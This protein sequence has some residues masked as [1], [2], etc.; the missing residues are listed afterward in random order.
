LPISKR[1][2]RFE[3]SAC[4]ILERLLDSE[5]SAY[6]RSMNGLVIIDKPA[7]CTS[8][9][10][11]NL[12]RRLSGS[13][14]V[15]H[16]GTLDP[17]AT[18]VLALAVGTATRLAQFY[19]KQEK[20]YDAEILF[21]FTS[22]T[23]D[24]EG[25]MVATGVATAAQKTVLQALDQFRGTIQQVP[26]PVSAKKIKGVPA[27]K[28]ARRKEEVVLEPVTIQISRLDVQTFGRTPQGETLSITVTGS[29]GTYI[30]SIAHDLGQM[31]GCGAVLSK[32]RRTAAGEFNLSGV[33]T[34]DEL[35]TLAAEGRLAEAV[36]PA[37]TL[38]PHFPT[39]YI[40]DVTEARIRQG[41][42]FRASPFVVKPGAPFVKAV[43]FSGELVAIGELKFP[44]V[45][46]P[47]IVL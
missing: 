47:T 42:E 8:H 37:R 40:D 38:L 18:G 44:N 4:E 2:S 43:S 1:V 28:L 10:V 26:P 29:A 39:A 14:R 11:V 32:L 12:W 30:R 21:G 25:E 31:L 34:P 24:V 13:R 36:L 3:V 27:Y 23:Y 33:R 20:T 7:A 41:R 16:L 45:Y 15:G 46:H 5:P 22:D 19:G 9:D 6:T 35:R 17:M